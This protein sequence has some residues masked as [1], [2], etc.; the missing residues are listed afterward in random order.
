MLGRIITVLSLLSGVLLA[1]MLFF[2]N[3][4]TV[5]PF[6]IF[7][8]FILVYVT[9]LGVVTFLM[10]MFLWMVERKKIEIKGYVRSAIMSFWPLMILIMSSIGTTNVLISMIGATVFVFSGLFLV[11]KLW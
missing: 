9:I 3:P 6:G 5:G 2:T 11:K 10:R 1:A 4:T 8:F 7:L